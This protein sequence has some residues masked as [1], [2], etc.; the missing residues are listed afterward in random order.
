MAMAGPTVRDLQA[1][2]GE[3]EAA[4]KLARVSKEVDSAWEPAALAKWMFQAVPESQRVGLLFENVRGSAFPLAIGALGASNET[5]AIALGTTPDG[6]NDRL[7]AALKDA[8][9]PV[10]V[11]SAPVHEIVW[12]GDEVDLAR[13]PI[14]V[15]TPGKDV[16]PYITQNVVTRNAESGIQNV[17]IYRTQVLGA[18]EVVVNL[19]PGGR[20]GTMNWQS[21]K[22][23]GER[24]PIAWVIGPEPAVSIASVANLPFGVDEIEFAGGIAGAPIE[25]VRC[26]TSDL[27]VPA[28]AQMIIEG[29]IT[30]RLHAEGPFGEFAGFMGLVDERPVVEIS[31]IT[32]RRA[33]V[34]YGFTSQM[35]PSESTIMQSLTNSGVWLKVL[36]EDLRETSVV[37]IAIDRTF[38]GLLGHAYVAVN[39]RLPLDAKRIGRLIAALAPVKMITLVDGDVD[40][41]DPAHIEWAM[42]SCFLPARDTDIITDTFSVVAIDPSI[43]NADGSVARGSK[44]VFD[45]TQKHTHGKFSLPE[46]AIMERALASW[47]EIGLPPFE[48]PKRVAARIARA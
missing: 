18:R 13:L 4:G 1:F 27:L 42:N 7:I 5:Y 30:D 29:F 35:P 38:G 46:R 22:A 20:H 8:R 33:P 32:M 40:V 43:R 17:A 37:D 10:E 39:A 11:G 28:H 44:I 36:R 45:A 41:R 14:P 16:G 25:L 3:L 34:F 47:H 12:R 2:L 24:A 19:S 48:I 31:A 9:K 23:R 6:I 26:T 15:W 21:W